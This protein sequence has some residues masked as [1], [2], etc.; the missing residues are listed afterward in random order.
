M[1]NSMLVAIVTR[2]SPDAEDVAGPH[3]KHLEFPENGTKSSFHDNS[4][5]P[6]GIRARCASVEVRDAVDNFCNSIDS[7][8]VRIWFPCRR[9]LDSSGAG[10]CAY[11]A[12]YP[13][14]NW[15]KR[16]SVVQ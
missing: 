8:A 16:G 15:Q 7:V 9:E 5:S 13:T 14:D 12:R 2:A 6:A 10:D 11:C 4:D 1:N 3:K